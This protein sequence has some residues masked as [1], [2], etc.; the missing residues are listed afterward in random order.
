[1]KLC[2]SL[3]KRIKFVLAVAL[4]G[5]FLVCATAVAHAHSP[6]GA[7]SPSENQI[8]SK[9]PA[10]IS[11]L[12]LDEGIGKASDDYIRVWNGSGQNIAAKMSATPAANGTI[13]S[14]PLLS[15]TPGWY[16]ANW[17]VQ[18]S[19]GHISSESMPSW[20]AFG[21]GVK[22]TA[23]KVARITLPSSFGTDPAT[24]ISISGLR[25]GL[26]KL[27]LPIKGNIRGSVQ[28]TLAEPVAASQLPLKGAQFSWTLAN[29]GKSKTV[30]TA[31]GILPAGG[32]YLV[33]VSYQ[34]L[35]LSTATTTKTW[36][37]WLTIAP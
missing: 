22:T 9:M 12:V 33:V 28:W 31:Q 21:V 24:S 26:R 6:V 11:L 5:G 10:N 16:A 1:M 3:L 19:D 30:G 36:S 35:S 37:G 23:A 15:G 13:M 7:R 14:A 4:A 17:S 20:W 29:D 34:P 18:F 27:S 2:R 32:K 8:V 25:V